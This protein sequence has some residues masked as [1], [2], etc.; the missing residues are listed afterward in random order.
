MDA[1]PRR[2]RRKRAM[3]HARSGTIIELLEVVTCNCR[4]CSI[5]ALSE[6]RFDADLDLQGRKLA[7]R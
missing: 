1:W 6:G 3:E 7:A 2:A 4:V 5:A